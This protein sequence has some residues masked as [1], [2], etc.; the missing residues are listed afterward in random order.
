MPERWLH[1]DNDVPTKNFPARSDPW[2]QVD[3]QYGGPIISVDVTINADL[4]CMLST[5]SEGL[6]GP[7][8]YLLCPI[9]KAQSGDP[10]TSF[11]RVRDYVRQK[12]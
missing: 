1:A 8:T 4:G 9:P 7:F 11:E 12:F 5:F 6:A 10:G 2:T 3:P